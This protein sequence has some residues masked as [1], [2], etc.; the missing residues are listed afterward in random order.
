M[1]KVISPS[2]HHT[3]AGFGEQQ[4][5]HSKSARTLFLGLKQ[6]QVKTDKSCILS[7]P[8]PIPSAFLYITY[9]LNKALLNKLGNKHPSGGPIVIT[10][11]LKARTGIA[12]LSQLLGYGIDDQRILFQSKAKARDFHF[13]KA[14]RPVK[15]TNQVSTQQLSEVSYSGV[16]RPGRKAKHCRPPNTQMKNE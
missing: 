14:Y 4:I 7:R 11:V 12:Q 5:S 9:G 1:G 10:N 15:K 3:Q 6:P 16:K 8:Y 13:P 2:P